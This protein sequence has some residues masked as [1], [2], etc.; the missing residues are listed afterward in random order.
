M[1]YVNFPDSYE[2][3]QEEQLPVIIVIH[4][5]KQ[6]VRRMDATT[7]LGEEGPDAGYIT[8]FAEAE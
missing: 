8:V 3:G 1:F 7:N 5:E 2:I 4:G 6:K